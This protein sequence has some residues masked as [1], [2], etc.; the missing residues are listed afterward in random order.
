MSTRR[1][2]VE[3]ENRIYD[4]NR[5]LREI[6]NVKD[7]ALNGAHIYYDKD[8]KT[9]L[10]EENFKDGVRNG[11]F[12]V[13][14]PIKKFDD[15]EFSE[16]GENNKDVK[17]RYIREICGNYKDGKLD[18]ECSYEVRYETK[19]GHTYIEKIRATY[20]AGNLDGAYYQKTGWL[21]RYY[22]AIARES[23]HIKR[24]MYADGEF[25]GDVLRYTYD[26]PELE[27][28]YKDGTVVYEH[29]ESGGS[30]YEIQANGW[31]RDDRSGEAYMQ[32]NGLKDGP[33]KQYYGNSGRIAEE[34]SYKEG[35]KDGVFT[36][37]DKEG[38]ITEKTSYSADKKNGASILYN[39][40]G[41]E[42]SRKLYRDGKDITEYYADLKEMARSNVSPV[43][44]EINPKL[45]KEKKARKVLKQKLSR[46]LDTARGR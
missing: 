43:K 18:G 1:K 27:K 23:Y 19:F 11:S 34:G 2:L 38:R 39:S 15:I 31:C 42:A 29:S 13:K 9:V 36:Y 41:T 7:G 20:Q 40:D 5:V 28:Q 37:Y 6:I 14:G 30:W 26:R 45:S 22:D 3:G 46:I 4:K 21:D 16:W 44:G 12:Y 25:S 32:K 8:G 35:K 10:A 24:G 17:S 33:Y